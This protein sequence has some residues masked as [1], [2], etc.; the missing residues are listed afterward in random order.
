MFHLDFDFGLWDDGLLGLELKSTIRMWV[1]R[2]CVGRKL[3]IS[4]RRGFRA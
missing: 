1:T 2:G 4:G 3:K